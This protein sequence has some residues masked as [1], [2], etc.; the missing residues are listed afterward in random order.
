MD[1]VEEEEDAEQ[2]PV[3]KPQAT[4]EPAAVDTP[5][6]AA[7]EEA[8]NRGGSIDVPRAVSGVGG[9][10]VDAS[11]D[12]EKGYAED[13]RAPPDLTL[14]D[15]NNT[16][17]PP[18]PPPLSSRGAQYG[19]F[20]LT[21]YGFSGVCRGGF[22]IVIAGISIGLVILVCL[23]GLALLLMHVQERKRKSADG[24]AGSSRKLKRTHSQRT[25]SRKSSPMS[26]HKQKSKSL[27][28]SLTDAVQKRLQGD[29][30]PA[31]TS[32]ST[33]LQ[34]TT[35]TKSYS[36]RPSFDSLHATAGTVP[37]R[38]FLS[39]PLLCICPQLSCSRCGT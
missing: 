11:N 9:M 10:E 21:H 17:P 18:P 35:P 31:D 32:V 24:G 38:P 23:L 4:L 27:I 13:R 5:A 26:D 16:P 39:P 34:F 2:V 30:V 1:D 12:E 6:A 22:P 7:P 19:F 36:S 8:V 33:K 29:S 14:N 3:P 25:L 20:F 15:L 37:L 28:Q